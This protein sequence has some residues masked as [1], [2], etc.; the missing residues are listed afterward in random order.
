[1]MA[2]L[3]YFTELSM[4]MGTSITKSKLIC[5]I[6]FFFEISK[7]HF[8]NSALLETKLVN[9]GVK[10]KVQFFSDKTHSLGGTKTRLYLYQ[11]LL[12]HFSECFDLETAPESL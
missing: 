1:M 10:H 11:R 9:L 12:D 4:T 3:C 8:Q 2:G 5:E 7:V 6:L